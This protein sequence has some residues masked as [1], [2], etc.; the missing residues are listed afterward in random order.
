METIDRFLDVHVERAGR[1]TVISPDEYRKYNC[2]RGLRNEDGTGVLVGLTEIGEV[3]GYIIDEGERIPAPGRLSYRGVDVADIVAGY[4]SDGRSGF[5]ETAY[6]LLFGTLPTPDELDEFTRIIA[7][8]RELPPGFTEDMVLRA[9]SSD[10]MNKL[11][12]S[13]LVCYSYDDRAEDT[14]LRNIISQCI[15]LIARFPAMIAYSY[16]AKRHYFDNESLY[17]HAPD[18]SLSCAENFLQMIRPDRAYTSIEAQTLDLAL[19]LHAEHGGGNNSAFT[20]HVVSSAATDAYSTIAA[21]IGSLKGAKHG[22]ANNRVMAMMDDIKA[23]VSDWTDATAVRDYLERIIRKEV[24]DQSGLIYGMGH[25]VYT[26]SDP[27][28]VLLKEKAETLARE[29]GREDEF[30]LYSL[31]EDLVPDAFRRVKGYDRVIAPNV[32][33]FS[34]FVYSMLNIPPELYT[35]IFAMSR[36]AGWCAHLI[37]EVV[38]GGRIIRPAYKCVMPRRPYTAMAER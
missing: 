16:Q 13:T 2:K 10:I 26:V 12:R 4:Q 24:G 9:P 27:R 32:D 5:E 37:E 7:S 1:T 14:S 19:V 30:R 11:A 29:K 36:I 20:V 34:G 15:D 28:A 21:A 17:I 6:L 35:P 22:G 23:N 33:F 38:S 31:I 8:R 3:H 18:R 25:A